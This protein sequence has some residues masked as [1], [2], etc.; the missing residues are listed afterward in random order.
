MEQKQRWD[1]VEVREK[2][3]GGKNPLSFSVSKASSPVMFTSKSIHFLHSHGLCPGSGHTISGLN[4][5]TKSSKGSLTCPSTDLSQAFLHPTISLN[6]RNVTA[7]L[8]P[9]PL[10]GLSCRINAGL[11]PQLTALGFL[12]LP[13]SLNFNQTSQIGFPRRVL[14]FRLCAAGCTVPALLHQLSGP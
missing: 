2:V 5:K 9:K 4:L 1:G 8:C 13:S 3:V 10:R 14:L 12:S 7:T 6:F 11:V